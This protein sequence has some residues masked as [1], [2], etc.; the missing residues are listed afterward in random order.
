MENRILAYIDLNGTPLLV[1]HLWIH[2][3]QS[4]QSVSFEYDKAWLN[5]PSRF[6]LDPA[7]QLSEGA[8]HASLDKPLFGAIEDSAPDRW[9]RLLMRRAE[10]K[11]AAKSKRHPRTLTE[12]DFLL[13]VD[14]ETRQGALRFKQAADGPFL[15]TYDK[16]SIPPL[17]SLE[18]LLAAS[19][20]VLQ[21]SDTDEDL[22]LILA[23]GSSLGGA[24]PKASIRDR[25]GHLAIAKFPK[26]DDEIDVI[27]WEAVAL[28]LAEKA[29]IATPQW[30]LEPIKNRRVL[31]SRRFDRR[32]K[33]RIPF[34]SAMSALQARD[35]ES[36]SYLEIADAI[37]QMSASPQH[38]L[39]ALWRR[40]VFNILIS[41]VDDHLRNHAFLYSDT[42]GWTLSPA[43]DLNPMPTD[44]KPRVLSTTIDLIDPSASLDLAFNV[45]VYFELNHTAM[46]KIVK[47]VALAT[48]EWKTT[49]K[50]FKIAKREIDRMASAFEHEDLKKAIR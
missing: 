49:A 34:L 3:K 13:L 9:G 26:T 4:R 38:D 15:T 46:K 5:M 41:N 21:D 8:F 14:D 25:D 47:E 20:R 32:Q 17:L 28:T 44:I 36:H 48:T 23:P 27:G 12:I 24:R 22:R 40:I 37:R 19:N 50:K 10:R 43:Y 35:N 45:G 30:R 33:N 6:S 11:F 2:S 29:T 42:S 39:R 1:G 31:I 7:L 18:K 16:N